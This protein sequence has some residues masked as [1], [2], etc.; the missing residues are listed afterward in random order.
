MSFQIF[1]YIRKLQLMSF[2]K[3]RYCTYIETEQTIGFKR[4]NKKAK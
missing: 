2:T 3:S 4:G 1:A